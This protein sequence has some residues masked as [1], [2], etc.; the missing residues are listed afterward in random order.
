MG[1]NP[2]P[3]KAPKCVVRKYDPHY[4]QFGFIMAVS[5]AELKAQCVECGE[6]LSNEALKPLKLQR[7]LN[8][9]HPG[10]V[11]KPKEYFQRKKDRLQTQLNVVTT[12]TTQSKATL[13]ASYM[14]AVRVTCS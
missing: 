8:T 14:V 1:D 6:I 2:A 10:F 4:I 3:V 11:G 12:L 13:K 9:K 7:H 5:D